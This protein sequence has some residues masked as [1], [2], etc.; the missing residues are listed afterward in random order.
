[1][2]EQE[3]M[4]A[5]F[6]ADLEKLKTEKKD[7]PAPVFKKKE[8]PHVELTTEQKKFILEYIMVSSKGIFEDGDFWAMR[9]PL[10]A[11]GDVDEQYGAFREVVEKF[12]EECKYHLLV[13]IGAG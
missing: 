7:R 1:M 8:V 13:T 3:D 9:S 10:Y 11:E 4:G 2:A 12:I 5:D 6:L